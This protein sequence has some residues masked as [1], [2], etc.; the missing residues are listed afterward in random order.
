MATASNKKARRDATLKMKKSEVESDLTRRCKVFT[1]KKKVQCG[2]GML[3]AKMLRAFIGETYC[4]G[5]REV[6][7]AILL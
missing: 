5:G 6:W 3:I 1:R 4:C 7:W 2:W